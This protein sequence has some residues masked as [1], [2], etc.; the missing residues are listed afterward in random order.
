MLG[1]CISKYEKQ[2]TVSLRTDLRKYLK[3]II[4][5]FQLKHLFM[6]KNQYWNVQ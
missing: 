3:L 1:K 6:Y 2:E 5:G 4:F